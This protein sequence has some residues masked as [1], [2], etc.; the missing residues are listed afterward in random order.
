MA[1]HIG[2]AA[3]S[4]EW[5]QVCNDLIYRVCTLYSGKFRARLPA[6]AIAGSGACK[7]HP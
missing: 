5:S 1:H 2:N 6:A 7:L 4:L 3:T